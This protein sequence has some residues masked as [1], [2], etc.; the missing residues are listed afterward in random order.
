MRIALRKF[1]FLSPNTNFGHHK[2]IMPQ[3][4]FGQLD[5]L[6]TAFCSTAVE[7]TKPADSWLMNSLETS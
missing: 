3:L 1:N 2:K 4:M 7:L 5:R 6:S